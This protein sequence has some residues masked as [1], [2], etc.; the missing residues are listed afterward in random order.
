[1]SQSP[2]IYIDYWFLFIKEP[3]DFLR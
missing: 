1:M 3:V 2:M